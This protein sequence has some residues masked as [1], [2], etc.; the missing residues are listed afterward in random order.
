MKYAE[1]AKIMKQVRDLYGLPQVDF[2]KKYGVS[3][4]YVSNIE[5]ALCPPPIHMLKIIFT[6]KT[7]AW[8]WQMITKKIF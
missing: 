2:G 7:F 3:A 5:R 4:Q 8:A 1:T 6:L